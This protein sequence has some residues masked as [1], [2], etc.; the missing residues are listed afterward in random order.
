MQKS[1]FALM[2]LFLAA[3]VQENESQKPIAVFSESAQNIQKTLQTD[4]VFFENPE[5]S[6][7]GFWEKEGDY[8]LFFDQ[9]KIKVFVHDLNGKLLST[10]LSK[11]KGPG[12]V[13]NFQDYCRTGEKRL[14]FSAWK[15]FIFDLDWK[16]LQS[17]SIDWNETRSVEEIENAPQTTYNGI[18]ELNYFE[19]QSF[20]LDGGKT[21]F[22]PVSSSHPKINPWTSKEYYQNARIL[23]QI[24]L[25]NGKLLKTLGRRSKIYQKYSF[26][27]SFDYFKSF[28]DGDSVFLCFEPDALI[29]RC[30]NNA[31]PDFAFGIEGEKMNTHYKTTQK[32]EDGERI[33]WQERIEKGYYADIFKEGNYF[34]RKYFT[35]AN[36]E[37]GN[38]QSAFLQI[39]E[40]FKLIALVPVSTTFKVLGEKEGIFYAFSHGNETDNKQFL[41][42]FSLKK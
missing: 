14:I 6:G 25:S 33:L 1:L 37:N 26:I 8:L 23:A 34:F 36:A 19:M 12:E 5:M 4:T 13:E 29:Y 31:E 27:P 2:F 10:H 28:P 9:K 18:Y 32:Y 41:V 21:V 15:I 24:D 7:V 35:G 42:K 11:G 30:N 40:H 22:L 17:V 20:S 16:F 3:C 38:I 39:Y